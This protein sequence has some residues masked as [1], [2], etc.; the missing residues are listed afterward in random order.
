[1]RKK[2]G[3][4]AGSLLMA[5]VMAMGICSHAALAKEQPGERDESGLIAWYQF[6]ED[7]K[8]LP[9]MEMTPLL[10]KG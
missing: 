3:K 2:Y 7:G 5:A 10:G 6:A 4:K 8:T 1:M 9:V